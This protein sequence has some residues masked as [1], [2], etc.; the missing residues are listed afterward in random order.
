MFCQEPGILVK[1]MKEH[2]WQNLPSHLSCWA[3]SPGGSRKSLLNAKKL[4]C[5]KTDLISVT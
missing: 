5:S 4:K 2:R 3:Y 1:G